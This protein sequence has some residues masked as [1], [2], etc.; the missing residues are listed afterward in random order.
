MAQVAKTAPLNRGFSLV[1]LLVVSALIVVGSAMAIPVTMSMVK[2]A[3]TDS[4][5]VVVE[6]F[7]DAAR[8]RAVAERRNMELEFVAPNR[9]RVRRVEVPSGA[10]TLVA[11]MTFEG[12]NEYYNFG[13]VPDTPDGFGPSSAAVQFSGPTPVMFTSDGSLIDSA[14][15]VTNGTIYV[16]TPNKTETAR[17]ITVFGV[18][19]MLQSWRWRGTA[20][21]E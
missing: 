20:W 4:S 18:T 2:R 21:I 6:T 5:L 8:D 15:D 13:S 9:L 17:A 19:G 7:V 16:A 11:E 3:T 14:G 10:K 12:A 1:E